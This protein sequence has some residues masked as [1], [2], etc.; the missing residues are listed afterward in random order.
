[1]KINTQR[2]ITHLRHTKWLTFEKNKRSIINLLNNA[3]RDVYIW[4]SLE[5]MQGWKV[6]LCACLWFNDYYLQGIEPFQDFLKIKKPLN[7]HLPMYTQPP[8]LSEIPPIIPQMLLSKLSYSEALPWFYTV[9]VLIWGT[10]EGTND[11]TLQVLA[12]QV[13]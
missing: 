5:I 7:H 6:I 2:T 8:S 9:C 4:I 13:K 1:M 10:P 12:S 11:L 3:N